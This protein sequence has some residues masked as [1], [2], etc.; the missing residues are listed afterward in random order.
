MRRDD[1]DINPIQLVHA[2][3]PSSCFSYSDARYQHLREC[4]GK[5]GCMEYHFHLVS[6]DTSQIINSNVPVSASTA[7]AIK[8]SDDD[9]HHVSMN[10]LG[11]DP[12]TLLNHTI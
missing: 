2:V 7:P 8:T 4:V 10:D 3:G 11:S 1:I 12:A 5:Q 6:F 9:A